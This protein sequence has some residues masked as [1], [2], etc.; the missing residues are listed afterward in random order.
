MK[1]LFYKI[2]ILLLLI[3]PFNVLAYSSK[4]YVGGD[5]IG[6]EVHSK[7]ILVVDF[8]KVKGKDLARDAGF[9]KGDNIISVN[10]I[11]VNNINDLSNI[12]TKEDKYKATILRD[13]DYLEINFDMIKDNDGILKSGMYLKDKINGVGTLTYI[14]PGTNIFGSLGHEIIE[15][16]TI[17]KFEIKDGEIYDAS[18]SNIVKSQNGR[19]GEKN[20][21]YN[22]NSVFGVIHENEV[23]GIF[24]TYTGDY[25]NKELMSVGNI[26]DIHAGDAFIRTVVSSKKI[27]EYSINIISIDEESKSKNILFE[28][29]DSKLLEKTGGIIQGMSGSPIIQDGKIIGA[30]NY[31]IVN[32][33]SKGYG[34]FI[35]TML[36]EGEN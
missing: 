17:S 31:V 20:S 27:E 16:S 26:G 22:R 33:T 14:D 5:N 11:Y 36:E 1:K 12:F 4:V 10:G 35:T 18:V 32:D 34:V 29:N 21:I 2:M 19:A 25:S 3:L 9:R 13:N 30:V 6:I 23:T 15:K 8:Y 24:G 7:G 28:V